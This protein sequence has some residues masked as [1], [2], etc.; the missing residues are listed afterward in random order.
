MVGITSYGAYIPLLRISRKTISAATGWLG[1]GT[2]LPGEKS[3]AG[4]DEDSIT[5]AVAAAVDCLG[6]KDRE[7][8]DEL[9]FAT[10]T[11]PYRERQSAVIIGTALDLRPEI[12]TA[13]FSNS[14]KSGTTALL[15]ALDSARAETRNIMVCASDC[16]Q[17]KAGGTQE[18][19][20]G[21]GAAAFT[22]GSEEVIA[23]LGGCYSLSYD[24]VD[25]WRTE[26]DRF[27]RVWE[28]R[29]IRDIGYS[30]FIPE[31]ITGLLKKYN[32]DIKDFARVIYPCLYPREHAAI[33][34]KLG[35][36][37]VQIQ[38]QLFSS[39]GDTGTAYPLMMLVAALEEAKPGERILL[40]SYGN[41]CDVMFFEVTPAIE[42]LRERRGTRKHII[43]K[44]ELSSYQKY[45]A[46][47]ELMM[48]DT[49]RRGEEI[50]ATQLSTLW[51]ERRMVMGLCGSRCKSCGTPQ[52]PR[53]VICAN[54]DCGAVGLM[55]PYRFSDRKGRLITFT[56]D[57]LAPTPN[58]PAIYGVVAFDGGG[59][60][61]FDLTDCDLE[62]LHVD[63]P[64]EM[65]FRRKYKDTTRG[66]HGYFW[67]ASPGRD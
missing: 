11:S 63:M 16:R 57:A 51:R 31:A 19:S 60:Y 38:D 1:S 39:V 33:G 7:S 67:K 35:A 50:G 64:V 13:D 48:V 58:P 25:Y 36:E 28:D 21:D 49:G 6:G 44:K 43:S 54:P 42:K 27:D 52:Y 4:Y 9:Y 14:I 10:T 65:S 55:D 46:F 5:M 30:K 40:T 62:S 23:T 41:G 2:G 17:G 18:Q 53:Q 61:T 56:G 45:A 22:V 47:R 59:R 32:L 8:M 37:P 34:K 3:V 24:F 26:G 29:W 15:A 66:I 20:C 12:R